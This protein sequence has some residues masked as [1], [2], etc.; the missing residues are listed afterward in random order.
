MVLAA[1]AVVVVGGILLGTFWPRMRDSW[2]SN[3]TDLPRQDVKADDPSQAGSL[4]SASSVADELVE[5]PGPEVDEPIVEDR[6]S[7]D[8]PSSQ[9]ASVSSQANPADS[10]PQEG[11][12]GSDLPDNS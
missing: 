8:A 11:E 9:L 2:L 6:V 4:S 5:P 3:R 10:A 1:A 7:G 12:L